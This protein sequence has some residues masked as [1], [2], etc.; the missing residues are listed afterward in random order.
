MKSKVFTIVVIFGMIMTAKGQEIK[1]GIK[2]GLNLAKL[3]DN[4]S[5]I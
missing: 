1:F 5:K 4:E 3:S 2:G